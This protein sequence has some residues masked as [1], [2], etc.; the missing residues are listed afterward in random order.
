MIENVQW[1]MQ[2]VCYWYLITKLIGTSWMIW[3]QSHFL[4]FYSDVLWYSNSSNT[5]SHSTDDFQMTFFHFMLYPISFWRKTNSIILCWWCCCKVWII[6]HKVKCTSIWI[7]SCESVGFQNMDL[8]DQRGKSTQPR[9][10]CVRR[11]IQSQF[12]TKEGGGGT[13]AILLCHEIAADQREICRLDPSKNL[14]KKKKK[15]KAQNSN[16]K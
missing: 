7:L 4:E 10:A 8:S 16:W 9:P 1:L 12:S 3:V 6:K 13:M 5:C 2:N 15:E 14:W 11:L